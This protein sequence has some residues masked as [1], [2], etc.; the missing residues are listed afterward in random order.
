MI[1]RPQLDTILDAWRLEYGYGECSELVT[2]D[3]AAVGASSRPVMIGTVADRFNA[4][5]LQLCNGSPRDWRMA[6]ALKADVFASRG[7]PLNLILD[8][9]RAVGVRMGPP[10]FADH[11]EWARAFFCATLH[12]RSAARVNCASVS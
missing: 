11:C 7:D 9:L 6:M 10:E 12:T 8:R 5:W 3:I 2:D 1:T 4:S